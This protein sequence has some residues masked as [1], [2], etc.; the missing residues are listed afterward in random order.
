MDFD[1]GDSE[2]KEDLIDIFESE[3][4]RF[5]EDL[6]ESGEFVSQ[7]DTSVEDDNSEG[8]SEFGYPD[9]D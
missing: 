2:D 4:N 5:I 3:V 8:S 1:I 7:T 9:K 6:Q